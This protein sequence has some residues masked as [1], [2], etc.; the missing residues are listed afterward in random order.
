[1]EGKVPSQLYDLFFEAC[2][3]DI[4]NISV[5]QGQM[6]METLQN[7]KQIPEEY[8]PISEEFNDHYQILK[9]EKEKVKLKNKQEKEKDLDNFF[10]DSTPKKEEE[11]QE[12]IKRLNEKKYMMEQKEIER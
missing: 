1:M 4:P 8:V 5:L 11:V 7:W 12:Y 10:K 9:K 2:L 6:A 3:G